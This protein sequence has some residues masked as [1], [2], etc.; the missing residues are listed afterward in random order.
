MRNIE[1]SNVCVVG[2]AGFLGS[3]LVDRLVEDR[4]CHVIVVDNL[5]VGKRE[6]VHPSAEFFYHDI[7][8]SE[9]RLRSMLAKN[10][11][12]F[13]FNYAAMPY[14]PDSYARPLR[15]ADVNFMGAMKVINAAQEAGCEGILQVSSAE[16]YGNGQRA[17]SAEE[18]GEDLSQPLTEEAPVVPHSSYGASKAAVDAFCQVRW[19][20]AKTPVIALRQF[21]CIGARESHPYVVTEI[22]SQLERWESVSS[23][24]VRLGNNSSRDFMWAGD[25]VRIAVDLLEAGEFGGVYNL[26]GQSSIRIHDLAQ[27]VGKVMGF[28]RVKVEEDPAR[29]R[30]WEIW[31]LRSCNDKLDKVLPRSPHPGFKT[32]EEAVRLAVRWYKSN[33][34]RW[35]WEGGA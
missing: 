14:V 30:P 34:C 27:L 6:W 20:E 25:A 24:V 19:R 13:V 18:W 35:P 16:V 8:S 17:Q 10:A 28:S 5:E 26:G 31:S 3:H 12:R 22:I 33:G 9:G 32:V 29:K 1:G 4:G 2:G 11:V 7:T 23:P 21:N 15:V